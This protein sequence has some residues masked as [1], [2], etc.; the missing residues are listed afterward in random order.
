M[1]LNQMIL[2]IDKDVINPF[3][4]SKKIGLYDKE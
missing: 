1:S 4:I 2:K 3:L